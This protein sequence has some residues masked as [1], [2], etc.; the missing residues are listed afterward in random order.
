MSLAEDLQRIAAAATRFADDDE[1]LTGVLATE[2]SA[3]VRTYLCAFVRGDGERTWIALDAGGHPVEERTTVREAVS[4]AAMC[5]L[6]EETAGGGDLDDLRSQL[7]ALRLTENPAGIDEAEEAVAALE[8]T[9]GNHPRVATPSY[10][11]AVGAA[12][13]RLE[14]TLDEGAGPS[15]FAEAMQGALGAVESLTAEIE[16]NYKFRLR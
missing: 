5:E 10:L 16:S 7:V 1:R 14:R 6:A 8:E 12:T 13:R 3:G 9:L 11:D 2:P 15:P 4:I